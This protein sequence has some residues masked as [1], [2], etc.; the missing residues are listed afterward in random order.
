[1]IYAYIRVSTDKQ[2][3]ENQR[4]ELTK[5]SDTSFIRIDKW[6]E[7]TVSTRKQLKERKFGKFLKQMKKGDILLYLFFL[8]FQ[9]YPKI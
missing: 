3:V 8:L 2:T 5:F 4:F 7:E 9:K 1:M 6:I